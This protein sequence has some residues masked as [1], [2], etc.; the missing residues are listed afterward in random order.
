MRAGFTLLDSGSMEG[1]DM[2][3]TNPTKDMLIGLLAKD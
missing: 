1:A 3:F 2:D